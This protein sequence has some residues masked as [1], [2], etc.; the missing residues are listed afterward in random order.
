MGLFLCL[1]RE[2]PFTRLLSGHCL[3]DLW[4]PCESFL[5]V[6]WVLQA[7]CTRWATV[8]RGS[9]KVPLAL[10]LYQGG[11]W[12]LAQMMVPIRGL[13]VQSWFCQP[14][15]AMVLICPALSHSYTSSKDSGLWSD[16]QIK[17]DFTRFTQKTGALEA[18]V[19]LN[20]NSPQCPGYRIPAMK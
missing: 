19:L 11:N 14:F 12:V 10:A 6:R 20:S 9:V 7:L 1:P 3:W 8:P 2:G 16:Y 18:K 17:K 5:R 13:R 15:T 4:L